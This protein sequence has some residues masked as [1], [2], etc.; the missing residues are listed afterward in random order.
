MASAEIKE[1]SKTPNINF[2]GFQKQIAK[3]AKDIQNHKKNIDLSA[4]NLTILM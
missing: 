1:N 4:A 2:F 3:I